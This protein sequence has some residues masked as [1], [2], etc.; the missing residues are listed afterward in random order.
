MADYLTDSP[1]KMLETIAHSMGATSVSYL[2]D[3]PG[4]MLEVIANSS[5][6]GSGAVGDGVANDTAAMAE[7]FAT[8]GE[9]FLPPGTYLTNE[10]TLVSGTRLNGIPGK[11]II[12]A[13]T[14]TTGDLLTATAD[15]TDIVIDGVTLD[16]NSLAR[17]GYS[18]S[19][20][21]AKRHK[22]LLCH[23]KNPTADASR[24]AEAVDCTVEG[25]T[26]DTP[27]QHG[28]TLTTAASGFVVSGNRITDPAGA[29]IIFS[30]GSKGTIANNVI[31][32]PG[33]SGDGIT[34]YHSSNVDVTVAG[35]TV[36]DSAN[37]G[38]HVGGTN[39]TVVGN[40]VV[41]S[42]SNDGI[43]IHATNTGA[44]GGA[45]ATSQNV[46][47]GNNTIVTSG[48]AAIEIQ[49]VDGGSICGNTVAGSTDHQ[50]LLVLSTTLSCRDNV[51][52]DGS[53]SAIV[54]RG[55]TD[56][57]VSAN[58]ISGH[59]SG[60]GVRIEVSGS[61]QSTGNTVRANTI[62]GATTGVAEANSSNNNVFS[63]NRVRNAS[64]ATFARVGASSIWTSVEIIGKSNAAVANTGN[65][66]ENTLATISLPGVGAMG[67][68]GTLEI[69]AFFSYTN[70]ANNKTLAVKLGGT[71][72]SSAVLTTTTRF[73]FYL[74][75]GNRNATNSQV[76]GSLIPGNSGTAGLATAAIDTSGA[77]DVTLTAQLA[78]AGETI[79]LEYYTVKLIR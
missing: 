59:A 7:W 79:T 61:T 13:R 23:I 38:I 16:C 18:A 15:A 21:S 32:N 43:F 10:L 45:S 57:D 17:R 26:I 49:N 71:T 28:I 35:N 73:R 66:N 42:T 44:S 51:V 20:T 54:I 4:K 41:G 55:T 8:G 12:K 72:V 47:V 52:R 50:V 56:S 53:A 3:S 65:T 74:T 11:S 33:P 62:D 14:G 31:T 76:I 75:V 29:G 27:G 58:T 67:A 5:G 24:I 60:N 34:G 25:N 6:G 64:A 68:T 70:S 40:T 9:K 1:A 39:L 78:S 48:R 37:H 2:T 19:G 69:E 30:V 22:I 77:V 46:T 63:D 36:I